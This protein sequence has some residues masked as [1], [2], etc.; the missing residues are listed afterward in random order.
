MQFKLLAVVVV[1]KMIVG[2]QKCF[3]FIDSGR[4]FGKLKSFGSVSGKVTCSGQMHMQT[5]W[6]WSK[7]KLWCCIERTRPEKFPSRDHLTSEFS[8][9]Y[10]AKQQISAQKSTHTPSFIA[11]VRAH[12]HLFLRSSCK[13]PSASS[14]LYHQMDF[15]WAMWMCTC[16]IHTGRPKS[17]A[18][19]IL[20]RCGK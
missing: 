11:K 16:N 18:K 15:V 1:A 3:G 20:L 4:G 6:I 17:N 13:I 9:I 14:Y 7:F 12:S 2:C 8:F 5:I 19:L 10:F